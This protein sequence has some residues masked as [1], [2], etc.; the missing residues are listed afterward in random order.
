[1]KLYYG[2]ITAIVGA[3]L[4]ILSYLFDWVDYNFV[5]FLG[6][7]LVIAGIGCHIYLNYKRP[8]YEA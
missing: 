5:Q 2:I 8:K 1:M 4:L 6:V 3:F 7:L